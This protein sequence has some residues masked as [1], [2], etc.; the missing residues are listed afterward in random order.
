MKGLYWTVLLLYAI[1][2]MAQLEN[3]NWVFGHRAGLN[4]NGA[5][6]VPFSSSIG[7]GNKEACA[8]VSDQSGNL[9]FYTDGSR[10]WNRNHA[11]M[12]NGS[13]IHG[14]SGEVT[15]SSQHGAQIV[16]VIGQPGK[17]YV[18]SLTMWELHSRDYGGK[19]FYSIV[20]MSLNGGLGDVD[21][22]AKWVY[23]DSNLSEK[24]IAVPGDDCN[25]W[26]VV[27]DLDTNQ[28]RA[29]EITA[30]GISTTPV[31]SMAGIY[32]SL[33]GPAGITTVI[34]NRWWSVGQINVSPDRKKLA[35]A[36]L[37]PGYAELFDFNPTT[38]MVSGGVVVDSVLL[39]SGNSHCGVAFS[40]DNSKLYVSAV[41]E[42]NHAGNDRAMYQFNLLA[43]SPA[44]IRA[45]KT[46][47]GTCGIN[48]H[49]RRARDGKIYFLHNSG[50]DILG[51]IG[52][53]NLPVP[54]CQYQANYVTLTS[55]AATT[56]FTL[57]N[58]FVKPLTGTGIVTT[59]RQPDVLM[60]G[61]APAKLEAP[62]GFQNIL[63]NDGRT[64]Q[65]RTITTPGT[66]WVESSSTCG[67][68]IDTFV[69]RAVGWDTLQR[70][71]DTA[72]CDAVALS[73]SVP[74]TGAIWDDGSKG[75]SRAISAPGKY[76]AFYRSMAA[77]KA[78]ADTFNVTIREA[79]HQTRRID[80]SI[81]LDGSLVLTAPADSA[82]WD[83]GSTGS[84]RLVSA[85]GIYTVAYVDAPSCIKHVD[86]FD[87]AL[88]DPSFELGADRLVCDAGPISL[89]P[90]TVVEG[91]QYRWS[92][93]SVGASLTVTSSG[94]YWLE[95]TLNGC[96]AADT[97]EVRYLE[98]AT[99]LTKDTIICSAQMGAFYLEANHP[100]GMITWSDGSVGNRMVVP[101]PG[102][103]WV[104]VTEGDCAIVDSVV[105]GAEA[106][107][108]NPFFPNAFSPNGDGKND[109]FQLIAEQ[110]CV[111][112][113]FELRIYDRWGRIVFFTAD[114]TVGW[115]GYDGK[116][117]APFGTYMFYS[118]F[119]AGRNGDRKSVKGDL[120][121]LR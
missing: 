89:T 74:D 119:K 104:T 115:D 106:C 99:G 88:V 116:S 67:G 10:I 111:V 75:E 82:V 13:M 76:Y 65:S 114:P 80:T 57:G 71:M 93:G 62:T 31:T 24:M 40:E 25:I 97:I 39:S 20:D 34:R 29:W 92:D 19:L 4:H 26:L 17:Y 101:R 27:H 103:Y 120:T 96:K 81:C 95:M 18:F 54:A 90:H 79:V 52:Q 47:V 9:L 8:S 112:S 60:C 77:C 91:G 56:Q 22:S 30:S 55:I 36:C 12:P 45:S 46:F 108:C 109:I 41:R 59:H 105:V 86:T 100:T 2:G 107:D 61:G 85:P 51:V 3:N 15:E 5:T 23:V 21:P 33:P 53:P 16:P 72:L 38:G 117:L 84:D 94:R 113:E 66:Y 43:G 44:A 1:N 110:G 98:H 121:L 69:V 28:F 73:L 70:T 11:L 68:R 63:W 7:Y 49:L 87:V 64:D 58:D 14:M 102:T 6:P 118:S 83:D 35:I 78:Y 37:A 42:T 32:G 48:S 50:T